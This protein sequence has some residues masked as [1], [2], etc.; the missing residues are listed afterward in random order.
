MIYSVTVPPISGINHPW[1][2]STAVKVEAISPSQAAIQAVR[3][4]VSYRYGYACGEYGV[5]SRSASEV[6][7]T[8]RVHPKPQDECIVTWTLQGVS[9]A[10]T[11]AA[12]TVIA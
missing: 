12:P 5:V 10:V 6:D 3:R 7:A 8:G 2:S 11:V 4:Q 9:R 1:G